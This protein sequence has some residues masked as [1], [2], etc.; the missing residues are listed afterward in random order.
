MNINATETTLR[1]IAEAFKLASL[2]DPRVPQPDKARLAACAEQAQR[3]R[4][5]DDLL[6]AVQDFYDRPSDRPI[7]IGDMIHIGR[8]VKRARLDKEADEEREARRVTADTKAAD[9]M[10]AL[11]GGAVMGPVTHRTPRLAAA[12]AALQT[13]HGRRESMTAIREYLD[14]KREAHK[15]D[16]AARQTHTQTPEATDRRCGCGRPIYDNAVTCQECF[17]AVRY[18][19]HQSPNGEKGSTG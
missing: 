4:L 3:H 17:R 8:A 7:S 18:G 1:A 12:Q 2:L 9:E 15:T 19:P 16:A 5:N 10:H 6:N 11:A 13:C 14:A